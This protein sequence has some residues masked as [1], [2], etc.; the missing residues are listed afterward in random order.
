[1]ARKVRSGTHLRHR[2]RDRIYVAIA[3]ILGACVF[4]AQAMYA[5]SQRKRPYNAVL[6]SRREE[7]A[8]WDEFKKLISRDPSFRDVKISLTDRKHIYWASG[9]VPSDD[10][11]ERLKLLAYQCGIKGRRLDGPMAYSVSLTV[12]AQEGEDR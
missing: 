4:V 5:H 12:A 10:D 11:L 7:D 9:T 3:C 6:E 1:M 8:Q 2:E